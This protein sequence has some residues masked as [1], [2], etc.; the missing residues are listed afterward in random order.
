MASDIHLQIYKLTCT[1]NKLLGSNKIEELE[2]VLKERNTLIN[3]LKEVSPPKAEISKKIVEL[4]S[5]NKSLLEKKIQEQE[6]AINNLQL[7]K[8]TLVKYRVSNKAG[9]L[10]N[11]KR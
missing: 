11:I 2:E 3:S 10:I 8:K 5:K 4:E 9:K 6:Q 7:A 1:I